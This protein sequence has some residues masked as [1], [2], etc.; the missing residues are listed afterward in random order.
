MTSKEAAKTTYLPDG[1][2]YDFFSDERFRGEREVSGDYPT[3]RIPIFVKAG[4]IIPLQSQTYSTKEKPSD[5]L[6]VHVYNGAEGHRFV[7]YEDDGSSLDYQHGAYYQ[8]NIDFHPSARQIVFGKPNG[9]YASHFKTIALIL[10]GFDTQRG[11][12]G[13]GKPLEIRTQIS[14]EV[15]PLADMEYLL[16]KKQFHD[17]RE[18]ESTLPRKMLVVENAS[19]IVISWE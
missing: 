16:D 6:Y 7:Y 18:K 11:F 12:T 9:N 17:L 14:R 15:D 1:D 5:T 2:W 10:H 4:A 13:N 3:Y 19:E 8:R